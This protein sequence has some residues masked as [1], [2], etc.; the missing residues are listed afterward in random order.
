MTAPITE[1]MADHMTVMV[2]T[3]LS[4]EEADCLEETGIITL[5]R[6]KMMTKCIFRTMVI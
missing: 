1:T 3:D 2:A 6:K 5:K 4:E